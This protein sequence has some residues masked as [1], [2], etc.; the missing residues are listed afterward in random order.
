MF[1]MAR[2]MVRVSAEARVRFKRVSLGCTGL[3]QL[4]ALFLYC[5]S[6]RSRAGENMKGPEL[7]GVT[8]DGSTTGGRQTNDASST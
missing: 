3:L 7:R 1:T 6:D 5:T 4:S 2:A 8:H